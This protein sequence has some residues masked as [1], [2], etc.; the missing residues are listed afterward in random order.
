[1]QTPIV[2]IGHSMGAGQILKLALLHPSLLSSVIAIEPVITRGYQYM[3]L[4]AVNLFTTRPDIW[5]SLEQAVKAARKSV[6]FAGWDERALQIF[7]E[8]GFRQLPTALYPQAPPNIASQAAKQGSI[9]VTL[10]TTRHHEAR[11]YARNA[12]PRVGEPLNSFQPS[13]TTHLDLSKKEHDQLGQPFYRPESV[14]VHDQ[15]PHLQPRCH[16]VYAAKTPFISAKPEGRAAKMRSTGAGS[17][18]S[19]GISEEKVT[20]SV[21]KVG[22]HYVLFEHP[23]AVAEEVAQALEGS[24]KSWAQEMELQRSSYKALT[25]REKMTLDSE[26]VWWANSAYGQQPRARKPRENL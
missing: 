16:Y 21:L 20:E 18:G 2:G 3:H 8:R 17:G 23:Q 7:F 1:M 14:Q 25:D 22:S 26:W 13:S 15:L 4:G 6:L 24:L 11:A 9:P 10:T 5:P 19:G 12:F